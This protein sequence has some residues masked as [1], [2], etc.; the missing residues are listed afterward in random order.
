MAEAKWWL[1][2]AWCDDCN[3]EIR[4]HHMAR[5]R[6]SALHQRNVG[7]VEDDSTYEMMPSDY[8]FGAFLAAVRGV[9]LTGYEAHLYAQHRA[10][11][12]GYDHADVRLGRTL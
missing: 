10:S 2:P 1:R 4:R 11:S 9:S 12:L 5:H 3:K 6:L 7:H 8:A